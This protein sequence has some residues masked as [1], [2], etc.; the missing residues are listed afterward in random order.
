MVGTGHN[1]LGQLPQHQEGGE[2]GDR[3]EPSRLLPLDCVSTRSSLRLPYSLAAVLRELSLLPSSTISDVL[4]HSHSSSPIHNHHPSSQSST[5]FVTPP[6][7]DVLCW[8][9][10]P[11]T[12]QSLLAMVRPAPSII[13]RRAVPLDDT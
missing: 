2:Q 10:L 9:C 7:Q 5:S 12:S 11:F 8:I 3:E 1:G 4:S 13:Y 6:V